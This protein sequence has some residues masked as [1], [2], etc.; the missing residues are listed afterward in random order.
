M[1]NASKNT[2][3]YLISLYIQTGKH[4]NKVICPTKYVRA[5]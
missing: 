1:M 5:K 4:E 2:C 3:T